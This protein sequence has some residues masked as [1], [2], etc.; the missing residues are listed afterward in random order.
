LKNMQRKY[1]ELLGIPIDQIILPELLERVNYSIATARKI[2]IMYANIHTM[3]LSFS[4]LDHRRALCSADM[5]YCDGEGVRWGARLQGKFLPQRMT[6]ADW[7]Y[8]L[9]EMCEEKSYS[10]YLLGGEDGVSDEAAKILQERFP[11]LRIAGTHYGYFPKDFKKNDRVIASINKKSS[12][13]LLVGF[14]SPLQEKWIDENFEKVN[15]CVVWAVGAV[16]D[17][18][19]GKVPR[20]PRWMLD[21]GMEWLFR[22][23]IEPRKMWKRYIIGNIIFFTRI[24]KERLSDSRS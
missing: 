2:K 22:L 11:N 24:I 20:G 19:S 15:S 3:N 21:N 12:D 9:C 18:V 16:V 5:V 23:I 4:N 6:G 8:D 14:G 17:F 10:L 7:I 13:I 1:V